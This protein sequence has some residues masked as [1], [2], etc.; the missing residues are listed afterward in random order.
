MAPPTDVLLVRH[1]QV[2]NP[3]H[4]V[5][6][7][8]PGFDLDPTGVS[9]AHAVG[10]H[11]STLP[12]ARVVSSPLIRAVHTATA[13]ARRHDLAVVTDERLIE[14][15]VSPSWLGEGWD[16]IHRIAPGE[17]EAYLANPADLPFA[18]E[19]LQDVVARTTA[20]VEAHIVP[21]GTT[22]YVAHQDPVAATALALSGQRLET[23]LA[24]PPPHASVTTLRLG[25]GPTWQLV[26]RWTP[27]DR[28][29]SDANASGGR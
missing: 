29:P 3:N 13:I 1:G 11:L 5:Y 12:I 17:V 24:S 26:G 7:H 25:P 4:V 2:R 8:L 6:G 27:G 16:D 21:N 22:V 9:E 15:N 20:A 23:L 28:M 14:W 18:H 19:T 10:R